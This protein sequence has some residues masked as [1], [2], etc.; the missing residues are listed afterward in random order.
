MDLR[1]TPLHLK[2]SNSRQRHRLLS[3]DP[4]IQYFKCVRCGRDLPDSCFLPVFNNAHR[5]VVY[6]HPICTKC[7]KQMR[8]VHAKH[9]LYT[10][11][12]HRKA[13]IVCNSAKASCK[14]RGIVWGLSVDD[15][16][17]MY[18]S[19]GGK[20]ALSGARMT[21]EAHDGLDKNWTAISIDRINSSRNY[22]I[23]NVQLVCV[24]VNI[25][26][27][28]MPQGDFVT[29]CAKVTAKMVFGEKL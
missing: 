4:S 14:T 3:G 18:L 22:T 10:P 27:N 8:S 23:D 24:A 1:Q 12:L 28:E 7:H 16:L 6:L 2:A 17:G 26:K 15:V 11:S 21:Y 29:W 25:M 20:C 19:Q 13:Q 9:E 5:G